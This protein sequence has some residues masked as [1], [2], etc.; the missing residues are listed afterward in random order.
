M[1]SR[2]KLF[3]A[4]ISTAALACAGI[5]TREDC[6][7]LAVTK[8]DAEAMKQTLKTCER[9]VDDEQRRFGPS[10]QGGVFAREELF[11]VLDDGICRA[12][13]FS[14][15]GAHGTV[16]GCRA[17][18]SR[19]ERVNGALVH[20]CVGPDLSPVTHTVSDEGDRVVLVGTTRHVL[21]RTLAGCAEVAP[22]AEPV[23]KAPSAR[24]CCR[25]L[26]SQAHLAT[27]ACLNDTVDQCV[28][29]IDAGRRPRHRGSCATLLCD[30]ECEAGL[31]PLWQVRTR[32][33]D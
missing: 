6:L 4:S 13:S 23:L 2:S 22:K 19:F 29:D 18:S 7:R 26:A 20:A 17:Q 11:H 27:D 31:R 1:R 9:L 28:A 16:P 3:A 12:T 5:E 14:W 10:E 21:H 8:D 15:R 32:S 25:C 24:A 30:A 33:D